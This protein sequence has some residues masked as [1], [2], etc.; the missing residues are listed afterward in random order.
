MQTLR[1]VTHDSNRTRVRR[2]LAI[3]VVL[4]LAAVLVFNLDRVVD[5]FHGYVDVVALVPEMNGVR[6]GSPVWV[7]GIEAGRV[8][9]ID[10]RPLDEVTVLALHL[11]LEERVQE[12]VRRGSRSHTVRDR[13]IGEPTVRITAGPPDAPPI[14]NGD[15]LRPLPVVSLDTL[16]ARG[17]AFPASL[18]SLTM[19]LAALNRLTNERAPA[20]ETLLDRLGVASEEAT[21]LR[22]DL[23]GGTLDRVLRDPE[24]GQRVTR[25]RERVGEL[26][27]AAEEMQARYG[28]PELQAGAASVAT[29]ARRLGVAL[30]RL[31]GSLA[32]GRG[33]IGRSARDS[34]IPMA[35]QG[36]QAQ[37]D[38]LRAAGLGFALRMILP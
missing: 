7:E 14:E 18:D 5:R 36:V 28:D 34:A 25:L 31:E 17:F 9:A 6:V 30:E 12:V 24:L 23:Q 11:R 2:G 1:D 35:V 33:F 13:F 21:A 3:L 20:V 8:T 19:A 22:M 15:T 29:R 4:L 38:S 26:T 32:D 37:I 16:L 27:D 10:F